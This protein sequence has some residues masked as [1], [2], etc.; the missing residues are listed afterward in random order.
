MIL[1]YFAP[2]TRHSFQGMRQAFVRK[3][4][5]KFF[6]GL[7]RFC[8][9]MT[10]TESKCGL[11]IHNPFKGSNN[12][13]LGTND[14]FRETKS[15]L[16]RNNLLLETYNPSNETIGSCYDNAQAKQT[17]PV[18][19]V[20]CFCIKAFLRV[21]PGSAHYNMINDCDTISDDASKIQVNVINQCVV[22]QCI[23]HGRH[24]RLRSKVVTHS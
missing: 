13:L 10:I 21:L 15:L 17:F 23:Q 7:W 16:G 14:L 22:A 19:S 11:A 9:R 1:C 12:S 6:D 20:K 4:F 24:C 3:D 5:F 2:R 18:Q 8:S